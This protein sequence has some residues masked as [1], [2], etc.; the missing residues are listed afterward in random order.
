MGNWNN[1]CNC[2]IFHLIS[3]LILDCPLHFN[4]LICLLSAALG[5]GCCVGFPLVAESGGYSFLQLQASHRGSFS[6][7]RAWAPA[8]LGFRSCG[9]WAQE[10]WLVGSRAPAQCLWHMGL[11]VPQHVWPSQVRIWTHVSCSGRRILYHW[12]TTEAPSLP[13]VPL[14]SEPH[15]SIT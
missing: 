7:C 13:L 3:T 6:C 2:S 11:A 8:C 15:T 14:H 9:L 4:N 1:F 5:L 10:L 12:A